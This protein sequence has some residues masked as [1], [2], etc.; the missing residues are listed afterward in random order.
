MLILHF[1]LVTT[2]QLH[3]MQLMQRESPRDDL[4]D[5]SIAQYPRLLD[6]LLLLVFRRHGL[7]HDNDIVEFQI[8]FFFQFNF[9]AVKFGGSSVTQRY[10]SKVYMQRTRSGSWQ[11]LSSNLTWKGGKFMEWLFIFS[12]T[13][14]EDLIHCNKRMIISA[15]QFYG[16]KAGV[17]LWKYIPPIICEMSWSS[18][19][20]AKSER[21]QFSHC[22]SSKQAYLFLHFW[23]N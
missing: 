17:V 16:P 12:E 18:L 15:I 21:T 20:I 10:L 1:V 3:V 13:V 2:N 4:I 14:N 22:W 23:A 7:S 19:W 6:I 5:L 11:P 9:P 8:H